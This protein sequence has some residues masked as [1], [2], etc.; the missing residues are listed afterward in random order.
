[1]ERRASDP[2]AGSIPADANLADGILAHGAATPERPALVLDGRTVSYGTLRARIAAMAASLRRSGL[3]PGARIALA[4]ADAEGSTVA[5]LG[6]TLAG[7]VVV[8]VAPDLPADE[9]ARLV[10]DLAIAET[11]TDATIPAMV[12]AGMGADAVRERAPGGDALATVMLSSGTTGRPKAMAISHRRQLWILRAANFALDAVPA[13]RYFAMISPS[14]AF[15]RNPMLRV[16]E[17]G[18]TVVRLPLPTDVREFAAMIAAARITDIS[19]TPGHIRDLLADWREER[20]ALPGLKRLLV[21]T[22]F[23]HQSERLEALRRISPRLHVCL[24]MNEVGFV[25][26]ARPEDLPRLPDTVGRAIPGVT[27]EVVD[28]DGRPLPAGAIGELRVA[29]P[30]LPDGYLDAPEASRI[31]FRSG[32]FHPGDLASLDADGF[33]HLLGRV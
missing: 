3:A 15:G 23:L 4:A 17:V 13:D 25:A 30:S 33:L 29:A 27:V 8:P 10:A 11:L 1:M 26:I 32:W 16:L 20:P 6:A 28:E 18:G 12:E 7:F 19:A 24:G 14:F 22:A 21:S 2:L 31:N 5:L 9:R